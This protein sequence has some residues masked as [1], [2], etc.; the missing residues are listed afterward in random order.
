VFLG[1]AIL[2]LHR[3]KVCRNILTS[4]TEWDYGFIWVGVLV[5]YR[6]R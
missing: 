6:P 3:K 4:T 5:H 1:L 2:A